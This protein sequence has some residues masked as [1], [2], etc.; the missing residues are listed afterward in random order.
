V[1][2]GASSPQNKLD[3][4]ADGADKRIAIRT[5]NTS[6][7]A[8]VEAQVNNY[9]SGA[10]YRGTALVQY[11][12][13]ATGT[14]VG[15]SNANLGALRFQN[16]SSGLIYTN[17]STPLVFGTTT[18]ERMRIDSSGNVGIGTSSASYKLDV[19]GSFRATSNALIG[20][21]Q[22]ITGDLTVSGGDITLGG[23]GRIQGIDTVSSSTDAVN[24]DYVDTAVASAG[25][26][27][28][29]SAF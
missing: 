7:G 17:G 11:D 29:F 3:V 15:L 12:S 28:A 20:G 18:S 23:T 8:A 24:K 6:G 22:T 4:V 5:Q 21:N 19:S 9:W 27:T 2:I 25:G 10:T 26:G 13:A 16:G 1:G 14:T